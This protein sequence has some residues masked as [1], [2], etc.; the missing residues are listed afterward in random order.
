MWDEEYWHL[1]NMMNLGAIGRQHGFTLSVL[2]VK[3]SA[4]PPR[5]CAPSRSSRTD[6][7][8]PPLHRRACHDVGV[9]GGKG[10]SLAR[11]TALGL[12]VPPGFVVCAE[13][14]RRGAR[15]ARRR[16]A[17]RAR[18]R[19]RPRRA[20][21][22]SSAQLR[23]ARRLERG[24]F[25][26]LGGD[27]RGGALERRAPRTPTRRASPASRRPTCTCAAPRRS[28][29]RVRRLLGVVL[30]RAR[31]LLP[32]AQGLA[33]RPAHGRRRAA[34][35]RAGR[36]RHPLHGRP[37]RAPP[38]PDGGRGGL[39][40][41]RAGGVRGAHAR[42]LHDGARRPGQARRI[43]TQPCALVARRGGGALL[44]RGRRARRRSRSDELR[45][46]WRSSAALL[47]EHNGAPQDIEWAIAGGELYVLQSRPVTTL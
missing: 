31:A 45:A 27:G 35:G 24:A 42:Q 39:R 7:A 29:E 10:A 33:R 8:D 14:V 4:R 5:R 32:R 23:A 1:E 40:P 16:R 26:A 9:A 22:R 2:P 30:Q 18:A 13:R 41:R 6:R 19:A 25:A 47:E 20:R 36:R 12:P 46:R 38:R 34:H 28:A 43:V 44:G 37:G 21:R 3:W 15:E 17:A 11:M